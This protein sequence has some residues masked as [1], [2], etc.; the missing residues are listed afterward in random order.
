MRAE[1]SLR[2]P[3]PSPPRGAR[4]SREPLSRALFPFPPARGES[5]LTPSPLEG[6]G[7]DGGERRLTSRDPTA[8]AD[9]WEVGE[10]PSSVGDVDR[11]GD[12]GL[13]PHDAGGVPLPRGIFHQIRMSWTEAVQGAI[14]EADLRFA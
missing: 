12:S 7:Q 1:G 11:G 3:S 5:L 8:P 4:L 14:A 9:G 2:A 13:V 6:E 10:A